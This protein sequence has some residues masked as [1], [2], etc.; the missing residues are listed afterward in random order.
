MSKE[1]NIL[2]VAAQA[3]QMPFYDRLSQRYSL[4]AVE[5]GCKA[6]H[7]MNDKPIDVLVTEA[8]LADMTGNE[9]IA[10]AASHVETAAGVVIHAN[11][12]DC[13][14]AESATPQGGLVEHL[15]LP[16]GEFTLFSAVDTLARRRNI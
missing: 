3:E 9:L 4:T 10:E 7:I 12:Q 14:I 11:V 2:L 5:C 1:L 6:L 13:I 16:V 8:E 15:N